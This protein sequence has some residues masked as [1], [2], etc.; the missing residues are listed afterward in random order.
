VIDELERA[1][2]TIEDFYSVQKGQGQNEMVAAL[3]VLREYAGLSEDATVYYT[4]WCAGFCGDE[5]T[6][7]L[8]LGLLV[9]LIARQDA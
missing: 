2:K 7:A 5:H 4:D 3:H 8:L 9:G 1:C 6:G